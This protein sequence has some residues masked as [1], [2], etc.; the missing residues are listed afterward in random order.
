MKHFL[1][2]LLLSV[3][4][5]GSLSPLALATEYRR[6]Y[7]TPKLSGLEAGDGICSTSDEMVDIWGLST[8]G[9]SG[10]SSFLFPS[11]QPLQKLERGHCVEY[12]ET[13]CTSYWHC[14]YKVNALVDDQTVKDQIYDI[15]DNG[16]LY[17]RPRKTHGFEWV[18]Y[19]YLIGY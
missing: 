3:A 8:K 2:S 6:D 18:D 9:G 11:F 17:R 7:P 16:F 14:H 10:L 4:I 1:P 5:T 19:N 15:V 13:T 12:I